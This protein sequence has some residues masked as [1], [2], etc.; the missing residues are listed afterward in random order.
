MSKDKKAAAPEAERGT[1]S[2]TEQVVE[3]TEPKFPI[4][5]LRRHCLELFNVTSSTFDGAFHGHEGEFTKAEAQE[6]I[7]TWLGGKE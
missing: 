3:K 6:I 5:Q 1:V 2:K 4:W 7:T